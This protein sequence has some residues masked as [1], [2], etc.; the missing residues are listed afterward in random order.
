[1]SQERALS[2][3]ETASL[4]NWTFQD[5]NVTRKIKVMNYL[6]TC[7]VKMATAV[8]RES[9]KHK[10][11]ETEAGH[12][13]GWENI[14]LACVRP[15]VHSRARSSTK[16]HSEEFRALWWFYLV[17][18]FLFSDSQSRGTYHHSKHT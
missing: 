16:L 11:S 17:Y 2:K 15:K 14:H 12:P 8:I 4:W 10:N 1:M 6:H 7:A 18:P 9:N 3:R 5:S 13:H